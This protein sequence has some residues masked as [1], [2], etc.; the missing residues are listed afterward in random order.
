M[1]PNTD[2]TKTLSAGASRD[3]LPGGAEA[4]GLAVPLGATAPLD[5]GVEELTA[6]PGAAD[7]PVALALPLALGFA[8]PLPA[9]GVLASSD[10]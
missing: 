4:D 9:V 7:E 6:L 3:P 8:L 2:V 5:A 10:G 1:N